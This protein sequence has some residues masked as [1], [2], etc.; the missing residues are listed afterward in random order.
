MN[1]EMLVAGNEPFIVMPRGGGI[2]DDDLDPVVAVEF[3]RGF[4]QRRVTEHQ[5]AMTPGKFAGRAHARSSW[6]DVILP[7]S[8]V[9]TSPGVRNADCVRLCLSGRS[10]QTRPCSTATSQLVRI[11]AH[12]ELRAQIGHAAVAHHHHEGMG[13][14]RA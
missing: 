6:H 13:R 1:V 8:I 2:V 11:A 14:D 9:A 7:D 12:D 10:N 5:H 3:A 4:G